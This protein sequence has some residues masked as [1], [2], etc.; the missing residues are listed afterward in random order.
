MWYILV[1]F[2]AQDIFLSLLWFVCLV[3]I[4]GSLLYI[5]FLSTLESVSATAC[6]LNKC[7]H[8]FG[9]SWLLLPP[10]GGLLIPGCERK[11]S[12]GLHALPHIHSWY[13]RPVQYSLALMLLCVHLFQ[14][15]AGTG[16]PTWRPAAA[17]EP[18]RDAPL[19]QQSYWELKKLLHQVLQAQVS[20]LCCPAHAQAQK[21]F[22][23][24]HKFST[25]ICQYLCRSQLRYS[26]HY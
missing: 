26:Q 14:P 12:V 3:A 10:F 5:F 15:L 25:K 24:C 7:H 20:C 17:A 16:K 13:C 23:S 1:P 11:R 9:S 2:P 8:P 22:Q 19:L 6:C 18:R 4:S 21:P